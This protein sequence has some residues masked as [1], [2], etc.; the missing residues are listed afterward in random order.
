MSKCSIQSPDFFK[1]D[2]VVTYFHILFLIEFEY[3]QR[4]YDE[5]ER[6]LKQIKDN[7]SQS[8]AKAVPGK[9]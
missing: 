5:K 3:F 4:M 9:L 6:K 1:T 7:I 2:T 8:M